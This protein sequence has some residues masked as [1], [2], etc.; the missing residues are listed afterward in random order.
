M[1]RLRFPVSGL[2]RCT[3][4]LGL[5]A[6]ACALPAFGQEARI[7]DIQISQPEAGGGVSIL[8]KLSGQPKSAGASQVGGALVVEIDGV[9]L[10]ALAFDPAGNAMVRHVAVT[11]PEGGAGAPSS[12]IRFEGAAFADASTTIYRDAVLIEARLAEAS[13]PAGASLMA[14]AT[15]SKTAPAKPAAI[16]PAPV[17]VNARPMPTA[18]VIQAALAPIAPAPTTAAAAL[19]DEKP[20]VLESRAA[21]APL[22]KPV[23]VQVAAVPKAVAPTA[24]VRPTAPV[25]AP[26]ATGKV[27]AKAAASTGPDIGTA[28]GVA[29]LDANACAGAEAQL[30]KDAWSLPALGNHALCLIDQQKLPEAKNRLDQLAAFSPEDWR[31]EL[32]RG[33]LAEK[34]GD[35]SQAE[36]GYRNAAQLAPDEATRT[37]ILQMLAKLAGPNST[38]G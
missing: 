28:A 27:I 32:G 1:T 22:A 6:S 36:I 9:A 15:P 24:P 26:A 34:Q 17:P 33:A 13:L 20:N 37:A 16:K 12:R 5:A 3:W 29:R 11:P 38:G 25:V 4:A 30:A 14:K 35:A 31:V 7:E 21:V 8:V 10:P 18:P 19:A 2:I 23:A